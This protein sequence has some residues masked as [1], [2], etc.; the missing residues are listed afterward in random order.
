MGVREHYDLDKSAQRWMDW[1]DTVPEAKWDSPPS[2]VSPNT[3]VPDGLSN[4]EF[5]SWGLKHLAGRP[6]LDDG[7][8]AMR[9]VRDLNWGA[10]FGGTGGMYFNDAS[11]LGGQQN[12]FPFDREVAAGEMLRIAQRHNEWEHRRCS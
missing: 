9:M 3:N 11:A 5:V 12:A 7:Y 8:M 2:F 6:D 1:F 4:Q 10:T